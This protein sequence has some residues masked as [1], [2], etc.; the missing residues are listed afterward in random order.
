MVVVGLVLNVDLCVNVT[1]IGFAVARP[2]SGAGVW[3]E[4]RGGKARVG[5]GESGQ[6][7]DMGQWEAWT[8]SMDMELTWQHASGWSA[9][10]HCFSA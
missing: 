6:G 5:E 10:C 4:K 7:E 8:S 1:L 9:S 3:A 2:V